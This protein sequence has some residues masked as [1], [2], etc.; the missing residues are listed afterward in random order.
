MQLFNIFMDNLPSILSGIMVTIKLSIIS[1]LVAVVLGIV[2]GIF[3]LSKIKIL[4]GIAVGYLYIIRGT[5]LMV[6]A[7][8]IY[9]GIAPLIIPRSDPFIC[10]VI[11]LSLNAGA[12]M[13]EIFRAGILAVDFGQMEASRSL[14]LGYFKTMQKVILPQAVKIMIPSIINQFIVTMKDTSILTVI[15]IRELTA[16]GQIIVA[17]NFKPLETYGVIAVMYFLL[18]TA[19]SIFSS[20][21]E[22]RLHRGHKSN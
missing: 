18:I 5:P 9:F 3:R 4:E 11:A 7:L 12:Y 15:S 6:Q 8:F 20:Y 17:R 21:V 10:G 1:L 22:R 19:L 14:G 16:S 13:S 2:F